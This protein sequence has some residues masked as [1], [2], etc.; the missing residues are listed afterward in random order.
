MKT[1]YLCLTS[2]DGFFKLT[3][4]FG[5][6]EKQKTGL[7]SIVRATLLLMASAVTIAPKNNEI[8]AYMK[9]LQL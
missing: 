2:H 1:V 3:V 8:E 5:R 9:Q 7:F 6:V 4:I